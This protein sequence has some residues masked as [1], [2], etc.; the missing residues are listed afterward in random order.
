MR[1]F[2]KSN[3]L[4]NSGNILEILQR[5]SWDHTTNN[6][7]VKSPK[8]WLRVVRYSI[9]KSSSFMFCQNLIETLIW[10]GCCLYFLT[11]NLTESVYNGKF[12]SVN[13][14]FNVTNVRNKKF[15]MIFHNKL[16]FA[17]CHWLLAIFTWHIG[18]S[19]D[20]FNEK[21]LNSAPAPKPDDLL[22][23]TANPH[24]Y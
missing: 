22:A 4:L 12:Y 10:A 17:A 15:T 8:Y 21:Y 7:L 6:S 11:R 20:S 14:E 16:I 19:N 23:C 1:N 9:F 2:S 5:Q 3:T 13:N 18:K 24:L